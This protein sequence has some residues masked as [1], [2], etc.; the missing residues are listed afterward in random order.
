MRPAPDQSYFQGEKKNNRHNNRHGKNKALYEDGERRRGEARHS[1]LSPQSLSIR[2]CFYVMIL[3]LCAVRS[4]STSPFY[5]YS[6]STQSAY[7]GSIVLPSSICVCFRSRCRVSCLL[8]YSMRICCR[9]HR[10][11]KRPTNQILSSCFLLLYFVLDLSLKCYM[12][13]V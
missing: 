7:F 9:I 1:G 5:V 3:V 12:E 6:L 4:F 11:N 8:T 10:L 2:H 13:Q